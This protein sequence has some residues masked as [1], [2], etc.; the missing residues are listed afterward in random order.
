M[1]H[2]A[3]GG[4]RDAWQLVEFHHQGGPAFLSECLPVR[5]GIANLPEKYVVSKRNRTS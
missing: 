5:R 2:R 1:D 3:L 4:S